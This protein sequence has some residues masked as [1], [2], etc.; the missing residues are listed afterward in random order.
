MTIARTLTAKVGPLPLW[1]Y[2]AA[3]GGAFLAVRGLSAGAAPEEAPP[4]TPE[5]TDTE[6]DAWG[7]GYGGGDAYGQYPAADGAPAWSTI[8]VNEAPAWWSTPPAW[9]TTP[10]PATTPAPAP[11]TTPLPTVPTTPPPSYPANTWGTLRV[12]VAGERWLYRTRR[13]SPSAPP[14]VYAQRKVLVPVGVLY[15]SAPVTFRREGDA[16]WS[17]RLVRILNGPYSGEWIAPGRAGLTLTRIP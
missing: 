17:L 6:L 8:D 4:A 15:V 7:A 5:Q 16:T 10:P 9:Y 11:G 1:A 3:A 2:A 12:T 14:L 13:K